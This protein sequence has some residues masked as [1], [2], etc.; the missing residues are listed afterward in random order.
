MGYD[1]SVCAGSL[2]F[3]QTSFAFGKATLRSQLPWEGSQVGY[4]GSRQQ[5]FLFP[6]PDSFPSFL[7]LR[8]P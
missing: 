5:H 8:S 1:L 6:L 3:G 2:A 4:D 7:T